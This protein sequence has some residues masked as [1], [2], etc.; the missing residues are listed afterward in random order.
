MSFFTC[1]KKQYV[2]S[3]ISDGRLLR[4]PSKDSQSRNAQDTSWTFSPA[5]FVGCGHVSLALS[6]HLV[7]SIISIGHY[8]NLPSEMELRNSF[9]QLLA[10]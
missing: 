8:E 5:V 2:L 6:A 1:I 7:A 10:K 9:T 3:K 4:V